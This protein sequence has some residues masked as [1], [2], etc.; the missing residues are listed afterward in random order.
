[1]VLDRGPRSHHAWQ[2]PP[3]CLAPHSRSTRRVSYRTPRRF[4]SGR[5]MEL[6]HV[7]AKKNPAP[8]GKSGPARIHVK[9]QYKV[10]KGGPQNPKTPTRKVSA[11]SGL[12]LQCLR[13]AIAKPALLELRLQHP[14]G[15]PTCE[16]TRT[17]WHFFRVLIWDP[18]RPAVAE[19]APSGYSCR[20]LCA[21]STAYRVR[22]PLKT[23]WR[24]W[25]FWPNSR[26]MRMPLG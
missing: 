6:F 21:P 11:R 19:D 7:S 9:T 18:S 20:G 15:R 8:A 22:S 17:P 23:V 26:R 24:C 16:G 5:N 4:L 1:M 3:P 12:L 10:Q 13:D 2:M 14:I 25:R